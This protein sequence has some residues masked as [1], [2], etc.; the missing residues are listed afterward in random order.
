M[1]QLSQML[2]ESNTRMKMLMVSLETGKLKP[3][4]EIISAAQREFE[5]QIKTLNAMVGIYGIQSKNK[6]SIVGMDRMNIMDDTT[7]IDLMLED[8]NFDKVK[9]PETTNFITRE[10]CLDISGGNDKYKECDGCEIGIV[11]KRKLLP[12]T[13]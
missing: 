8:P 10:Q 9:C 6:R 13:Y 12:P 3:D 1:T 7:A 11:T 5:G 4:M 2:K